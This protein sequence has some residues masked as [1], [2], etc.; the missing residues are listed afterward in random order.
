MNIFKPS[1]HNIKTYLPAGIILILL[2]FIDVTMNSFFQ[3]NLV[4]FFP[5]IISYFFSLI[6][7]FIGLYL[8][9]LEFSGIRNL[10]ILNKNCLLY[11]SPSQRD[12][13]KW[14]YTGWG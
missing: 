11:T 3:V 10:D 2:S 7:G 12:R 6:I 9:M 4:A 8:I 14:R 13:Q 1:K 5:G